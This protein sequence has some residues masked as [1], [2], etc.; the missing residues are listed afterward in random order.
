MYIDVKIFIEFQN[1]LENAGLFFDRLS[2][3]LKIIFYLEIII[4]GYGIIEPAK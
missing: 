1:T 2:R 4:P 3:D